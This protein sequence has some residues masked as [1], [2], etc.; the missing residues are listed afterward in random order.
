M[1]RPIWYFACGNP[2][3]FARS[4]PRHLDLLLYKK[5]LNLNKNKNISPIQKTTLF[6]IFHAL[7]TGT[8][9]FCTFFAWSKY[10][11]H[12]DNVFVYLLVPKLQINACAVEDLKLIGFLDQSNTFKNSWHKNWIIRVII[13]DSTYCKHYKVTQKC[14]LYRIAQPDAKVYIPVKKS[15]IECCAS[16]HTY[17]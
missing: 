2:M 12:S 17:E 7:F 4:N 10:Q 3:V 6:E 5:K 15:T 14:Y 1:Q 8:R 9:K 13:R 11:F 16:F